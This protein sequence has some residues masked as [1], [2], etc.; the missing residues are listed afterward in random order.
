MILG[1]D[2]VKMSKSRGNVVSPEEVIARFGAD[3]LRL[4][5]MFMGPVEQMKPWSMKGVE[6]VHRFLARVWRLAFQE[7]QEGAWVISPSLRDVTPSSAVQRCLHQT[8]KKVTE[9]TQSFGFNTAISQMMILVN[10][11]T[12]TSERPVS[13]LRTLLVLLSPYA[14]HLAEEIWT[15]LAEIFPNFEGRASQEKWPAWDESLL[16]E[17]E[18]EMVVQINGKVR[19]RL[20]VPKDADRE[21]LLELIARDEKILALL[22]G[23]TPQKTIVVPG[24]LINLV[25]P[26]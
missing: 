9:D 8:I 2:G 16:V 14:P 26:A 19:E 1:S 18:V 24:K 25:V 4:Y 3:S 6:G 20:L 7:N 13:C 12:A 22:A 21:A 23:K 15:R 10:E 11:L 17:S 5:E